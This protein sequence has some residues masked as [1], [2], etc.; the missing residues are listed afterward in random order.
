MGGESCTVLRLRLM[1]KPAMCLTHLV[2]TK[3]PFVENRKPNRRG[4]VRTVMK[5]YTIVFLLKF[6]YGMWDTKCN[7]EKKFITYKTSFDKHKTN[8]LI[9]KLTMLCYNI[10]GVAK[11]ENCVEQ[12]TIDFIAI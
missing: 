2:D 5:L 4:W 9:A 12:R 1:R 10:V 7:N 11:W 8:N 3:K 6:L